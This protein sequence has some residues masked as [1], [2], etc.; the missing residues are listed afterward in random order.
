VNQ[1]AKSVIDPLLRW[2]EMAG[3]RPPWRTAA[4]PY[5]LA[6]AEVLLQKTKAEH[7][8]PVWRE[9]SSRFPTATDLVQAAD[10]EIRSIVAGLGLGN[11]R[12]Q[13]LKAMAGAMTGVGGATSSL[14]GLG[15]YGSSI[16]RLAMEQDLQSDPIDGNVARVMCRYQGLSFERG[17]PRKKREVRASVAAL[18]QTQEDSTGKLRVLYAL[19]DLGEAVCKPGRPNCRACPLATTCAFALAGVDG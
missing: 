12:T 6:V 3:R 17:E 2:A 9:L 11:Q 15:P 7:V 5:L 1:D 8:E 18:L 14:P 16:V 13:R 10:D 19:V 4:G